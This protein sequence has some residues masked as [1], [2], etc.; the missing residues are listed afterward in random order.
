[1]FFA[2]MKSFILYF[3]QREERDIW[4]EEIEEAIANKKLTQPNVKYREAPIWKPDSETNNT[5]H[6]WEND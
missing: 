3:E 1:M 4:L 2:P 5:K 6:K